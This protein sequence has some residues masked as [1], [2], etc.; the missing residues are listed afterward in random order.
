MPARDVSRISFFFGFLLFLYASHAYAQ[1]E[2]TSLT[3][4]VI[5]PQGNRVPG[6]KV[7]AVH[8]ATGLK[9][10]TETTSQGAYQLADLPTGIFKVQFS[11][12]GFS[13]YRAARIRQVVGQTGT[14]NVR[15]SLGLRQEEETT[16]SE[17]TVQLDKVDV[18]IGGPIEQQQIEELPINGRNWSTLTALA[19]GA[20]DNGAGDQRTIRFAGH[21]LDD[22]NLT[23]DGVDA[24]AVFNQMQR[25][26]VRLTIPLDSIAEF[27]VKSQT[28]GADV[29]GGT[30]GGQI[31]VVSPSGT[32]AFHG[33]VFDYFRNDAIEA[34]TPFDGR[35]PNPFLLN[36]FGA[37][38]GGPILKD[39]LFFYA[40]YEGLRQRLDGTQIGLVPSP[41]FIA[42]AE[43]ASPALTP[44]LQAFPGGTSPAST[45]NVW[46]YVAR[47]RQIDNEDSG[48]IRLDYHFSAKTTGFVRFNSDEAFETTPAGNLTALTIF[49]TKFNNG[50]V[51]LLHVFTQTLIN[52]LKFGI[53]QDFYHSGTLSPLPYTFSVSGFSSFAGNSTSDNPSKAISLLDDWSWSKGEHTLKFGFEIKRDFLNQGSSSKGTVGYSSTTN[54]LNNIVNTGSY[55][56][57]L[58]LVRQRKTQYWMYAEDEW[59]ASE[60]LTVNMGVRYNI[61][62]ALHAVDNRAVPFDFATCGGFCPNTYS[63][64][65]PRYADIDPRVGIAWSHGN[66]V[67]RAGGGIYHTDGQLDDQDLP[68]SNTVNAYSFN[69]ANKI[70]AGLSYPLTP[71]L[72]YAEAGGLSVVSPRDLDRNRKDAYVAAWTASAQEKLPFNLIGTVSY[73]GNKGANILTTTYVNLAA[74]PT[75][76]PPYPAFGAVSWRGDVGNSTFEALQSN[77][78]RT[79]TNGFLLSANYM[80]SHSINDGSIGGGESDTPQN[81]FCR[82]C[83]KASSD[84]DIR[85]TFNVSAVYALPFRKRMLRDWEL[86]AIGTVQTGLPVNIT[87][88]R[89][90]S[91]VPGLFAISGQ[92][93]PNYVYGVPLT[94]AGGSV[95]RGWINLAAFAV[96]ANQTFGNLGRNAFRAPGISQLDMGLSKFISITEKVNFRLR[97]DLFN[98]FNRAQFGAP[99]ADISASNF[100]VITSTIS[101]YATGRGTPRE[102]QFS[103]KIVF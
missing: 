9:R 52:E 10:E 39:K 68:I 65:N 28:F 72:A 8:E 67:F 32:N 64:F 29:E 81:S 1:T 7:V 55:T 51:E 23:L 53:N 12:E 93:R 48:M 2:R 20:I 84:D 50:E 56:A 22:N 87:V 99:N 96:P 41:N 97:A 101:N 74:P 76:L 11:K 17:S 59:K 69:S 57:L 103:A 92:E 35:S 61:F 102:L 98:V 18:T 85:Q 71:F 88:D 38:V 77:L 6:A 34:R 90:N 43:A 36:Q 83:D 27:D 47:G 79:F 44:I 37:A 16:V 66:T 54:F 62:N 31:A 46:N 49:D 91:A 80:W 21:G 19:P 95:P 33:N 82:A 60:N 75:N 63:Y 5:D 70:F 100:G 89:S 3:G 14:L 86:S 24:T 30:S 15:L 42:Q 13:T 4:V 78:R 40:S 26:Y 73:L 25:E 45:A 58:P 94:P